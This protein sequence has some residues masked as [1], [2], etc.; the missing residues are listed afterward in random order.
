MPE[1][2]PTTIPT[3]LV[4]G[5]DALINLFIHRYVGGGTPVVDLG[6]GNLAASVRFAEAGGHVTAVDQARC[7]GR[8]DRVRYVRT[9]VLN[10]SAPSGAF[11][12]GWASHVLEHMPDPNAFLR[13]MLSLVQPGGAVGILV[14]PRKDALVGGHVNLFTPA[15]LCYQA[16]L[17]GQ[18]L[19]RATVIIHEYNIAL[20]WRRSDVTLPT[21]A[22]D[23]GDIERLA[24]LFP[25]PVH[26]DI[27]G[28]AGW[29]R[30]RADDFLPR[31]EPCA[32]S[33]AVSDH[34]ARRA[35]ERALRE[36]V[37]ASKRRIAIYGAGRH[38]D[39][40][41]PVLLS[42][43]NQ[44]VAIL[45][46]APL[47]HGKRIGPWTVQPFEEWRRL[48]V[49]AILISSD[50]HQEQMAARA[51]ERTAGRATVIRLYEK[52]VECIL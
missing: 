47:R 24:H 38:T 25:K 7:P 40:I 36:L 49:D 42:A 18:D 33:A 32:A 28:F 46:D 4:D 5:S 52:R 34:H 16:I 9:D 27:D 6:A 31:V 14:P 8:Y 48:G 43:A 17:T 51:V 22:C 45:D 26:Q 41:A 19:S 13:K 35:A 2:G 23:N 10:W 12:A 37:H 15:T 11:E 1:P 3:P 30:V 44:V 39:K 20:Y 29:E 50:A 21:L